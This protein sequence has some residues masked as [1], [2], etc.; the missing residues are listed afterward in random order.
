[1]RAEDRG[2]VLHGVLARR[3]AGAR[4]GGGT[5]GQG[6]R[7]DRQ[8]GASRHRRTRIP[9]ARRRGREA[10]VPGLR[11]RLRA[12]VGADHDEPGVQPVGLGVRR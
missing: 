3:E 12:P 7:A 1:M 6:G 4:T 10:D 2:E 11:R 8:G 5:A 9:A